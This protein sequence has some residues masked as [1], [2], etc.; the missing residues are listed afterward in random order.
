MLEVLETHFDIVCIMAGILGAVIGS[1]LNVVILRYPMLLKNQWRREAQ[2]Y[3]Q[4]SVD[5]AVD[6]LLLPRSYCINCKKTL[7]VHHL[8]PVVSYFFL[9]GRCA[10]CGK[11]ISKLYPA[12][13]L[14]TALLFVLVMIKYGLSLA[15]I[16]AL[17]LTSILVAL[18]FIDSRTFLLPDTITIPTLW[19]GLLFNV[20][21]I[22]VSPGQSILAAI[23]GYVL[24]WVIAKL[25]KA[26]RKKEGLGY[27]DFKMLAM[28]GAWLG[29]AAMFNTLL[30]AVI[31]SL[32]SA[33][34]LLL[35]GKITM[36]HPIPLGPCI[37]LAGWLSLLTG[38]VF[39]HWVL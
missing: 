32:A 24:L 26:I 4:L 7:R 17:I 13:E 12:V 21:E 28:V 23:L 10:Y 1:F 31:F 11:K 35:W 6:N 34:V 39:V 2:M 16:G 22:F 5:P 37:A 30:L 27:G 20:R 9:R 8:I 14:L 25:F 19:L 33:L 3:L 38:P 29:V 18:F 36:K 15:T